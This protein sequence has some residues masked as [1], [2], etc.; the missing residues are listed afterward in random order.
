MNIK[1]SVFSET[2]LT[3]PPPVIKMNIENSHFR[4]TL[5]HHENKLKGPE[6]A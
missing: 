3:L 2:P 6:Y 4:G 1:P 5:Y